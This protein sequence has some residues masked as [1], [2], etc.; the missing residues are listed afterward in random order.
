[1]VLLILLILA[2]D[3]V[4]FSAP[5]WFQRSSPPGQVSGVANPLNVDIGV[6]HEGQPGVTLLGWELLSDTPTPGSQVLLRLYWQRQDKITQMLHSL[7]FVYTPSTQQ[8]WAVQ[9]NHNPGRIPTIKWSPKLYYIDD[10]TLQLPLDLAPATYTLAVGMLDQQNHRLDVPESQDDLVYL[11]EITVEPL[12]AG[13]RQP[14]QAEHPAAAVFGQGLRLQGYDL[15]PDPG[16][17]ILR[18][19]W[20][21]LETPGIDYQTFVHLVNEGEQMVAQF[22]GPPLH[23]LLNTSQ[24][25][26]GSL[27]IDRRKIDL[28]ENLAGGNYRFLVGLYERDTGTRLPVRPEA[29]SEDHFT[30]DALSIPLHVP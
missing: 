1:V 14:L 17:P 13:R 30:G 19:Y 8:A 7:A 26:A 3:I 11:D 6:V 15:L 21:V 27:L 20:E 2:R 28:P 22:D 5:G 18:L 24:W 4:R 10:L 23:G 29:G 16:G 12:A 25:P 9:Q